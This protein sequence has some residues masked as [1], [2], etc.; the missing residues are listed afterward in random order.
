M[1]LLGRATVMSLA[2]LMGAANLLADPNPSKPYPTNDNPVSQIRFD[3]TAGANAKRQQLIN[4]IWP[5]GLPTTTMPAVTTN[6]GFNNDLQA[7]TQ[8]YVSRV[9]RLNA[10]VNGLDNIA[11]LMTPANAVN[12]DRLAIVYM[13]HASS[14]ADAL[15]YGVGDAAN[16]LLHAGYSVMTM[17]MPIAG[18]N[19]DTTAVVNGT[20]VTIPNR[21]SAGHNDMFNSTYLP[22]LG[23][24]S[25]VLR[26]FLEPTVQAINYFQ[27]A[28]PAMKDVSMIG[29]S[30]GGWT[31][32][33]AS[34]IDTRIKLSIPVAGSAPLYVQNKIG[35]VGDWEQV[36][37][38][39]FGEGTAGQNPNGV[40]TYLETYVLGAYGDGR[41]QVM[42]TIPGE[43]SGLFPTT[44]A[45]D[46]IDGAT[47]KG[48][49]SGTVA[50]MGAGR[51]QQ[52]YDVSQTTHEIS[53]WTI[54]NV[55]LPA[56]AVP[57]PSTC[58]LAAMG[59][60]GLVCYAWRNRRQQAGR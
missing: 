53:P 23:G 32:A 14:S 18:W 48:L 22:A 10:Q 43:P 2:L 31:T 52:V 3:T 49:V 6:V 56:M 28:N 50:D 60:L 35:S 4:Y 47:V 33:V 9:D 8:S 24:A 36:Y 59:L 44:W 58:V 46:V 26:L 11:Y 15:G 54:N 1:S 37:A 13:G 45:T 55:I 38:P 20:T 7:I 27:I 51:W 16:A 41:R 30:G 5:S 25:G 57:E 19:T 42:V 12:A 39:L 40:V 21:G 17:Q 34:A 29:L